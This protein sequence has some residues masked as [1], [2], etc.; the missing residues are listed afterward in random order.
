MK[1]SKIK[2]NT[3]ICYSFI[4]II[5]IFI[6]SIF[7]KLFLKENFIL[8]GGRNLESNQCLIKCT[9]LRENEYRICAQKCRQNDIYLNRLR[10]ATILQ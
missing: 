2:L 10:G 6:I 9:G 3:V 1:I 8:W 4:I 5:S 7:N